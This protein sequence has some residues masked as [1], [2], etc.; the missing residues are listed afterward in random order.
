MKAAPGFSL[1]ELLV[2][3]VILAI[4]TMVAII[5]ILPGVLTGARDSKRLADLDSI[6]RALSSYSTDKGYYPPGSAQNVSSWTCPITVTSYGDCLSLNQD[7]KPYMGPMVFDP[8][9]KVVPDGN[10][11]C[12]SAPCYMYGT[13]PKDHT[14]YCLCAKLEGKVPQE[15]T[16][17]C[18][19]LVPYGNYCL[20]N[21]S[22]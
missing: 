7:L 4:L 6:S 13:A 17:F 12:A 10:V 1:I 9:D 3:L 11:D 5:T 2:V 15:K 19:N 20:T 16:A 22:K 21:I 8:L 18:S 14:D